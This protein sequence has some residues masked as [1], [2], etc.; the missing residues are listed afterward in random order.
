[1]IATTQ[2]VQVSS[3]AER[4]E[5]LLAQIFELKIVA[6]PLGRP[7]SRRYDPRRNR[8]APRAKRGESRPCDGQIEIVPAV[9]QSKASYRLG[10]VA[11]L[12]ENLVP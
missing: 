1:L 12:A 2:S 5:R 3:F 7:R 11:A 10:L 4:R 9:Q 8:E 6:A